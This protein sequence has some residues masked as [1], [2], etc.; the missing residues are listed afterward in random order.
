MLG[1]IILN[2]QTWEISLRC[3]K[4]I[5]ETKGSLDIKIYLVDNAS[6]K[7]MP[8]E[9][10]KYLKANEAEVCFIRSETNRGYAAGN[11]LGIKKALEDGCSNLVI[12]NNDILFCKN[13]LQN[14]VKNLEM[15]PEV[16]IVGP[17][18]IDAKGNIQNSRCSM[19][20][21]MKEMFQIYTAAKVVCKKKWKKYFCLDQ[22]PDESMYP[23]HVSGCCFAMSAKC[24]GDITPFDEGTMLYY[25]EPII[26]ICMEKAGYRT[27]Y[28]PEVEII[29]QHGATTDGVQPLMYQCICESELYYCSKYL[30][31]KQ[32]QLNLL[33]RY[34]N[35]LYWIRSKKDRRLQ[36][37]R[38][39]YK[40][41]TKIA[42]K[43]AKMR[44]NL[45]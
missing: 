21:G 3:M 14:F 28:A 37:Y 6:P 8:E 7:P 25:E 20:T 44:C 33:F 15:H 36:E 40:K 22:N 11:N 19:K 43:N 1:I 41:N 5:E 31:A 16:G 35:M 10:Q 32:W 42:Y 18:V 12:T 23:Y 30:H 27:L 29:H 4:S 24:A 39:I 34:R 45:R 38:H 13:S 2:Y 26:G 9:I 17:K